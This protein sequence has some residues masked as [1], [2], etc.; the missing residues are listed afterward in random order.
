VSQALARPG[1]AT[2]EGICAAC[3]GKA[4]TGNPQVGAPDLTDEVWLYGDSFADIRAAIELGH[5]GQMPAQRHLL[6]PTRSRLAAA[7]VWSLSHPARGA[8]DAP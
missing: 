4:G 6:G 2:F 7:Y 3:H 8:G 5:D 1:K